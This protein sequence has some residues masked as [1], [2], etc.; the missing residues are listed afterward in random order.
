[1]LRAR[2]FYRSGMD[3]SKVDSG[4][5][6][7]TLCAHPYFALAYTALGY[8]QN[9]TGHAKLALESHTLA[10][11]IRKEVLGAS[12][13][14]VALSQNQVAISLKVGFLVCLA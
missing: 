10:M 6:V 2:A 1:M 7:V 3:S 9:N 8:N 5:R 4:S 14:D 11:N 12:S 13:M